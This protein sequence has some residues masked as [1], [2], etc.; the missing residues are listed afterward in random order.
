MLQIQ[1]IVVIRRAANRAGYEIIFNDG[2]AIHVLK[3]R[4]LVAL[5]VLIRN[6]EG[7]ESDLAGGS[8]TIPALK[9]A[10]VGKYPPNLIKDAY[11]DA[12]KPFSELWTEEGFVWIKRPLGQR[13]SRGQRYVLSEADHEKFFDLIL[14][15]PR[16][17]LSSANEQFIGYNQRLPGL[18]NLC[19][20]KVVPASQLPAY[21][22]SRDR[23]RGVRDHRTPIEKGGNNDLENIQVLCFYCN[24]SK[25]QICNIC[26][27]PDCQRC[28][29]AFP[30]HSTVVVPTGEDI[31][32]RIKIP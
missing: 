30:E 31:S 17:T 14:K 15:T 11:G 3:P 22:F 23:L 19:G 10:L 26:T 9:N 27:Q 16:R 20:A 2:R 29:L 28:V 13:R 24:K 18:C 8:S 6:G 32:D 12:N 7:S 1:N 21:P 4:A 25:W 5:L